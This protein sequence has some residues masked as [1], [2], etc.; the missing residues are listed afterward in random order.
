MKVAKVSP[1]GEKQE[2]VLKN[3]NKIFKAIEHRRVVFT[4]LHDGKTSESFFSVRKLKTNFMKLQNFFS[5]NFL[6]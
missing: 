4:F 1:R 6:P 3:L 2:E 5:P